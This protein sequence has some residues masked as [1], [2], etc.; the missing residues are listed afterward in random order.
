[1]KYV[2]LAIFLT[3]CNGTNYHTTEN[4]RGETCTVAQGGLIT[5]PDGTSYQVPPASMG[6]AGSQGPVG[7]AG[8]DGIS[9]PGPSGPP[10]QTIV[11]PRGDDGAP[12]N[13]GAIGPA[14]LNGTSCTVSN[15]GLVTCG[16]TSYQIPA[17][18]PG[19]IGPQGNPGQVGPAGVSGTTLY[20]VL[21]CPSLAGNY[22]EVFLCI[23]NILYAVYDSGQSGQVHYAQIGPGSYITT[24]N[25][26]C[27]FS[28]ISGCVIQ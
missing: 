23:A 11:G 26:Q 6:P 12:G 13:V 19:E 1:M 9:I 5:C 24:D 22:P 8:N 15:T 7:E 25:R 20:P 28:V 4:D 3:G 10:G 2:A 18:S 14:G 17:P 21:P 27:F 16:D